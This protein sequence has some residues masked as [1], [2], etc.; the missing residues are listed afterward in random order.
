MFFFKDAGSTVSLPYINWIEISENGLPDILTSPQWKINGKLQDNPL[1]HFLHERE[2]H[3]SRKDNPKSFLIPVNA[4]TRRF[5]YVSLAFLGGTNPSPNDVEEY[6]KKA[7]SQATKEKIDD[8]YKSTAVIYKIKDDYV[9][10][11]KAPTYSHFVWKDGKDPSDPNSGPLE[12]PHDAGHGL[13]GYGYDEKNQNNYYAGDIGNPNTAGYDPI[14]Y[15]HHCFVDYVLDQWWNSNHSISLE[16]FLP[17]K[18]NL[19]F[20]KNS[21]LFKVFTDAKIEIDEKTTS[22][23]LTENLLID[24]KVNEG[25]TYQGTL[26]VR[27]SS[28]AVRFLLP[29][30]GIVANEPFAS[31]FKEEPP[32]L[33]ELP[34]VYEIQRL[35][36]DGPFTLYA[37][38]K[39]TGEILDRHYFFN[40]FEPHKCETCVTIPT[41]TYTFYVPEEPII[42]Y[43]YGF[44]GKQELPADGIITRKQ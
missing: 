2:L 21:E 41:L 10:A 11:M 34:F 28:V 12:D 29:G 31:F 1:S 7:E 3:I 43:A 13:M 15:L 30:V 18:L 8:F 32:Q 25:I 23:I 19:S 20:P 37:R 26:N 27:K 39:L 4:P 33:I 22:W 5:P 17:E 6:N 14:F 40:R 44:D 35:K 9:K 36:L 38:S 42:T 24:L 16:D